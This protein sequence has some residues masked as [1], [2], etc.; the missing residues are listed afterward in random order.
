[1]Q[2]HVV[3]AHIPVIPPHNAL[4]STFLSGMRSLNKRSPPFKIP[5]SL[6]QITFFKSDMVLKLLSCSI[7]LTS[8]VRLSQR[9]CARAALKILPPI[10][11]CWPTTSEVNVG[12]M[13]VEVEPSHQYPI[14]CCCYVTDGSRGAIWQKGIWHGSVC[15]EQRCGTK[16][17]HAEKTVPIDIHWH[18][19][20]EHL[21]RPNSEC[22]CNEVVSVAF[23]Q[24]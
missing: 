10:L 6:L 19:L 2:H 8:E 12:G 17:L 13:A 22:E 1:M 14:T 21:W 4:L 5:P 3:S 15:M 20:A 23:Q 24:W 16:F 18:S 7:S 11:L 9:I